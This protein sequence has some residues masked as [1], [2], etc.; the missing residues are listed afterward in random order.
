MVVSR[1]RTS[2]SAAR[3]LTLHARAAYGLISY[4]TASSP[5]L[6]ASISVVPTPAK[7]SNTRILRPSLR[8]ASSTPA[9][10]EPLKPAIHGTQRWSVRSWFSE[11]PVSRKPAEVMSSNCTPASVAGSETTPSPSL[12]LFVTPFLA[13][14][15]LSP[16]SQASSPARKKRHSRPTF[17]D[18][19]RLVRA[20]SPRVFSLT[21]MS[22]AAS[23]NVR[24]SWV[25]VSSF[26]FM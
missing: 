25:P 14:W 16:A 4:P 1:A 9:T 15:T 17:C 26:I 24:I 20:I 2:Y 13:A 8:T 23:A 5:A 22:A 6:S 11:N 10:N 18:G 12:P 3:D 7:G 19:I 21:R